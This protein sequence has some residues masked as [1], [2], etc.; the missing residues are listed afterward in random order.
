MP[1]YIS[2]LRGVN[3]GG[4]NLIKMD[5]LRELYTSLK[6][7]NPQSYV[8]SGNVV[9]RSKKTDE[10][11]LA[12]TIRSA[13]EKTFGFRPEIILRTGAEMRAVVATNPFAKR[14]GIEPNKLNIGFLLTKPSSETAKKLDSLPKMPEEL[15]LV[16]RE[17]Y[18][19][20]PDGIGR[21]KLPPMLDRLLKIPTTV[22]NWNSVTKLVEIASRLE[23]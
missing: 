13:I 6:L 10:L 2:M 15:H 9:F 16:G 8:Q 3:V 23:E 12:T 20:F 5:A 22:R 18:I 7:E 11:A 4:H 17:L 1:V 21:S 19:Y 14:A